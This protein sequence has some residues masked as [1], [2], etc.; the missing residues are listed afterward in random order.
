[1]KLVAKNLI[2][3]DSYQDSKARP[4]DPFGRE[5][6]HAL[7]VIRG[8]PCLNARLPARLTRLDGDEPVRTGLQPGRRVI[9]GYLVF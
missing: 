4:D 9:S 8:N 7:L 1:M 2:P 6:G 3:P 5:E